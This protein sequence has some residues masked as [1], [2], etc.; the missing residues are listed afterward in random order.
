MHA[1]ASLCISEHSLI[2][3]RAVADEWGAALKVLPARLQSEI[4]IWGHIIKKAGIQPE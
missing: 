4:D 3:D 2:V 1:C